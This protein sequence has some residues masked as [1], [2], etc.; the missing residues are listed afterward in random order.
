MPTPAQIL[1]DQS[2]IANSWTSLAIVWHVYVAALVLLLAFRVRPGRRLM[3][4]LLTLPL[5]S[6]SAMAWLHRV[7]FNGIVLGVIAIVL[8]ATA[9][10]F[11]GV[12]LHGARVSVA[13]RRAWIP[14]ALLIAYGWIYPH[15][16]TGGPALRYLYESPVGLI[17]CPTL[18]V[19]VGLSMVLGALHSCTWNLVVG[20]T[21]VFYGLF[22]AIHLRV[23]SDWVLVF[24][25]VLMIIV[26]MP[27]GSDEA[28]AP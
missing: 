22:G 16:L 15:F 11:G 12:S 1:S 10:R 27:R 20:L 17:P 6:V 26:C 28:I 14:G 4:V 19:V 5:F 3:G 7:P 2:A 9:G 25:A 18:L 8:L 23:G 21:G 24:G 13:G